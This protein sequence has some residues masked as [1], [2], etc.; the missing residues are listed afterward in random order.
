MMTTSETQLN[1]SA[2]CIA[3]STPPLTPPLTAT[4][5]QAHGPRPA[6]LWLRISGL[7]PGT[8][9]LRGAVLEVNGELAAVLAGQQEAVAQRLAD[10]PSLPAF[11]VELQN[12]VDQLSMER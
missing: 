9:T 12:M 11:L 10:S 5:L 8:K 2:I 6:S 1:N 3:A 4:P 7:Q